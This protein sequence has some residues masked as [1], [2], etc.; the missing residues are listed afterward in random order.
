[1]IKQ[2]IKKRRPIV[3]HHRVIGL[4]V[5]PDQGVNIGIIPV[6]YI[7][8]NK[9]LNLALSPLPLAFPTH[10]VKCMERKKRQA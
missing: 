3:L 2:K 10:Y 4:D 5:A 7:Y 6:I 8:S 9:Y 1:M